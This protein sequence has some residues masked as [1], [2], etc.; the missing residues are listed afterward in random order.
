MISRLFA[1]YLETYKRFGGILSL[2]EEIALRE[3]NNVM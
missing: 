2:E 3:A 1:E